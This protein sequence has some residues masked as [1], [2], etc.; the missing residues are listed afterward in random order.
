MEYSPQKLI[1]IINQTP[2]GVIET[3]AAGAVLQINA[4]GVQLLMPFFLQHQLMGDNL[5]ALFELLAPNLKKVLVA[6]GRALGTLLQQERVVFPLQI[7]NTPGN[8]HFWFSVNRAEEDRFTFFFD[9]ITDVYLQEQSLQKLVLE[10]AVQEGKFEIASGMLHD[11]GNA[12]VAFGSYLTRVKRLSETQDLPNLKNLLLFFDRHRAGFESLIGDARTTAINTL[13][14]GTIKNLAT[15]EEELKQAV[16]EQLS[17]ITHIQEILA[18][19]RQY[20]RD[21]EVGTSRP[22]VNVRSIV[23][24]C[25]TMMLPSFDKRDIQVS[26]RVQT[27][28]PRMAGDQTKLMQVVLN[29]LKNSQESLDRQTSMDKRID[30]L[31]ERDERHLTVTIADTG[32]G[33]DPEMAEH[34]F[35]KG[36]SSKA[37]G[38]GLGLVNCRKIVESYAGTLVINSQ[39]TGR[40]AEARLRFPIT[41][42]QQTI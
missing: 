25:M 28:N 3:D 36:F 13:L 5:L 37:E 4:K 2:V 9:D 31:I 1:S 32:A 18:I 20:V 39:G 6:P 11:I 10:K 35:V 33:F 24:D 23:N 40:G 42:N 34:L 12:V 30:V 8:R 17:I 15:H 7:G 38:T 14:D 27:E 41:P 26:V 16:K 19:Q 29:L 21:K 22:S